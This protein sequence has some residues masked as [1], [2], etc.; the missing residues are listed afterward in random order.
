MMTETFDVQLE[1]TRDE[2][3]NRVGNITVNGKACRKIVGKSGGFRVVAVYT[4]DAGKDFIVKCDYRPCRPD[5]EYCTQTKHEVNFYCDLDEEDLQYFPELV[6]FGTCQVEGEDQFYTWI[7]QECV[8]L[9]FPRITKALYQD[10][11]RMVLKYNIGDQV[12]YVGDFMRDGRNYAT[13]P[14]GRL[15]IY[16]IGFSDKGGYV[17]GAGCLN[18]FN[19][20]H[21]SWVEAA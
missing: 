18:S 5:D 7:V 19:I 16:D 2:W 8:E 20:G 9:T 1:I 15:C 14:D 11:K 3:D 4:N 13:F 17:A 10:W 21:H 6:D 12:C